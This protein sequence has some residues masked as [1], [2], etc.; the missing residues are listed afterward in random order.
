MVLGKSETK[1]ADVRDA[2][3]AGSGWGGGLGE[4]RLGGA[5]HD[6]RMLDL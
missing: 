6:Q 3:D 2:G 5:K 4:A 1:V